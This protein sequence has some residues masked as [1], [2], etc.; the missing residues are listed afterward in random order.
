MSGRRQPLN[1]E[2][3]AAVANI[4]LQSEICPETLVK[5]FA[6]NLPMLH[7]ILS[8]EIP[9]V[10]SKNVI[11]FVDGEG[12]TADMEIGA[13][14]YCLKFE[15]GDQMPMYLTPAS[16]DYQ[17]LKDDRTYIVAGG[18]R[19]IGLKTVQWMAARGKRLN[20]NFNASDLVARQKNFSI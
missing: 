5:F 7:S 19:G 17:G 11:Q 15:S 3:A 1:L 2:N 6:D 20:L 8:Q 9:R 13:T 16:L 12:K 10:E 14:F 18:T 4:T